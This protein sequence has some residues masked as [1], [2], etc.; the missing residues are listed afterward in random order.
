MSVERVVLPS[1]DVLVERAAE[2][3]TAI[4]NA[5]ISERGEASLVLA[6]GSTPRAL[7]GRLATA[8]IQWSHIRFFF[9]DERAV[10]PAHEDS[11]YRMAEESLLS[12]VPARRA[13]IHPMD[14]EDGEAG[15]IEYAALLPAH[16]DL[17]LLGMGED[18]HTASLFP[19]GEALDTPEKVAFVRQSP[20]P[21]RERLTLT[22]RAIETARYVAYLVAGAGKADAVRRIFV[23]GEDLPAGSVRGE[24]CVYFLDEAAAAQL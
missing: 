7:Y 6:G 14:A 24:S 21:P 8:D 13:N 4:L 18:G 11:N 22:P 19:G 15:A 10:P 3:V 16:F 20:K 23:D 1:F 12:K 2:Y 5:A 9:G 17:V